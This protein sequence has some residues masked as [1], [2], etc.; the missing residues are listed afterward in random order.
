MVLACRFTVSGE[1][2]SCA[3]ISFVGQA[4]FKQGQDLEFAI[5]QRLDQG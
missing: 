4:L 5:R 1:M 2:K 3:A